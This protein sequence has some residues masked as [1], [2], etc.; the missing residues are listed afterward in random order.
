MFK[1]STTRS[2]DDFNLPTHCTRA[3]R[4][5][6]FSIGRKISNA[7]NK[8]HEHFEGVYFNYKDIDEE[9]HEY[10]VHRNL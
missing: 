5:C 10:L 3:E 8:A 7:L 6:I 2:I 9:H 1:I 4:R